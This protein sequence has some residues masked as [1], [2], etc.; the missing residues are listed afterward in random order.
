MQLTR[1]KKVGGDFA[2]TGQIQSRCQIKTTT[3]LEKQK[4][5]IAIQ[6]LKKR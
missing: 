3:L 6:M 1:A 5:P 4:L 2:L